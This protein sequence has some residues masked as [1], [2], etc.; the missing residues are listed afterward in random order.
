MA[1]YWLLAGYWRASGWYYW[2]ARGRLLSL[3][4]LLGGYRVLLI[5]GSDWAI[6][7]LLG[8]YW[9]LFGAVVYRSCLRTGLSQC[10][11]LLAVLTAADDQWT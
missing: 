3:L 5:L 6:G 11:L 1:N 9:R 10:W 2:A 4:L 8:G 7:R